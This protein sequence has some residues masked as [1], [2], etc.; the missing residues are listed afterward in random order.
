VAD[1]ARPPPPDRGL[2]AKLK[3]LIAQ[4]GPL[5]VADYMAACLYD[6]AHGY[7]TAN[8]KLGADGD[9]ITAPEVSQVFGEL[10][11]LWAVQ[12]WLELDRPDP[13]H[14]IELGPGRGVLMHDA[15]RATRVAPGF[16]QAVRV[17]M[18][19]VS[20]SLRAA[21][22]HAL[23]QSGASVCWVDDIRAIPMGPG[24][25]LGNEF[26]DCLPIRQYVRADGRW[27]ERRVGLSDGELAFGLG[28]PL[29][30]LAEA[31]PTLA[32]APEGAIAEI[33]PGLPAFV[34][35]V[36]ARLQAAPGRALMVDYGAAFPNGADT[37]QAL[38]AHTKQHPL[39]APGAA[40][41]TAHVDFAAL[42]RLARASGLQVAGPLAQGRFLNALGA[43]P[44]F[45]ALAQA[46]PDQQEKLG[47]QYNR[48][49]A[50]DQMGDLF[51]ALCLSTRG[52][53]APAGFAQPG[54]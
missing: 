16:L 22:Q 23:A 51:L 26:L 39:E 50:P 14:L 30:D 43:G 34:D 24:V 31:P 36:A 10:L 7:Y 44:R 53:P 29:P 52:L 18:V 9:F 13:F 6:P 8:A 1:P 15:L 4:A 47:R 35:A 41:L 11:G 25:T 33:A 37:L 19:E 46:R 42:S 28:A 48:L 45:S 49:T 2:T 40:D 3:G 5:S 17:W 20:P 27:R 32:D 54:P 21:Q 38:R 12:T